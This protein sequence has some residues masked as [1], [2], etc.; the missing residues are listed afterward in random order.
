VNKRALLFTSA[1]YHVRLLVGHEMHLI[2]RTLAASV[3][4]AHNANAREPYM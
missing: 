1:I 2:F 3:N 4:K